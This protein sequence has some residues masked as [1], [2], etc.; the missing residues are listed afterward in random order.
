MPKPMRYQPN[1]LNVCDWTNRSS[2]LTVA[3]AVTAAATVP[4]KT[5]SQA[6]AS[7]LECYKVCWIS[8][9]PAASIVG[10]PTKKENSVAAGR[11]KPN[12][13]GLKM[14]A[15]EREVPGQAATRI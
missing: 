11:L 5:S 4:S 2:H 12:A 6:A 8:Q 9:A 3:N 15:P 10:I 1:P 13:I 14:I 7:P